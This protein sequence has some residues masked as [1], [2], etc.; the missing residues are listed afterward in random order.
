MGR[1]L[2]WIIAVP[3]AVAAMGLAVS[4]RELVTISFEPFP[5]EFALPL[6]GVILICVAAGA[7][8]GG[9]AVWW[10][11]RGRRRQARLDRR[12]AKALGAELAALKAARH[13]T[14]LPANVDDAA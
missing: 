7:L 6:Y 10:A 12:A 13:S 11:G 1:W 9:L 4:N 14:T 3:A 2:R 5:L 8:L